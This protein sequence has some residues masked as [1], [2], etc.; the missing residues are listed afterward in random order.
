MSRIFVYKLLRI[1]VIAVV[2]VPL[3][4]RIQG[5]GIRGGIVTAADIKP[6]VPVLVELFTSEGCSSCP[7]ADALLGKLDSLQPIPGAK[8]I[9][10]SEHVTYWD[11]EGWRDPFSL[12]SITQRQARYE[13]AL[14]VD[15]SYTPQAVVDGVT[16]MVGSDARKL[17]QA[18]TQSAAKPKAQLTIQDAGWSDGAVHFAVHGGE[19]VAAL[20]ATL[21]AAVAVDSAESSVSHGE[22]SGKLLKHV[23]VVRVLEEMK[24]GSEDGRALTLKLP[25]GGGSEA[26]RLVVFLTDRH[27][28]RVLAVAQQ[29]ISR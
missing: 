8:V 4:V 16:E 26:L 17:V 3:L 11:H 10:L 18:V 21:V 27:T 1:S 23:A 25:A 20:K 29:T 9:V 14:H 13:E 5:L 2:L 19:D 7:P 28:G 22:N 12:D 6:P 24:R 15:S